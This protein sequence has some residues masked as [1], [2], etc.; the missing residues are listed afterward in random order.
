[1]LHIN[2]PFLYSSDNNSL[3]YYKGPG[4]ILN[5]HHIAFR[6]FAFPLIVGSYSEGSVKRSLVEVTIFPSQPPP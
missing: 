3:H 1:M 6:D 2:F 5:N 4:A